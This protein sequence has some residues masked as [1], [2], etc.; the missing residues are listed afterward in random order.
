M[1]DGIPVY[2]AL[3]SDEDCGMVRIS[4]VDYPAVLTGWQKFKAATPSRQMYAIADE[5]KRI[6]FGVIMRADFPILRVDRDGEWYAIYRADTIRA[7][8]E[9]YLAEGRQ[10]RVDTDHNGNEVRGVQM[11][12][13]FIKDTARGINP[14]GFEEEVADGSLFA[15]FHIL[16]D[17][18][19][20]AIKDG[21]FRGFSLEGFFDF[22][23]D[24]DQQDIDSI[25]REL[26]EYCEHFKI[27]D[28]SKIEKTLNRLR[29]LLEAQNAQPQKFGR[30]TTDKGIVEW[31]GE[32]DLKE[33]DSVYILDEDGNRNAAADGEYMT[34]DG[35]T[36]VVVDG[37]VSE[38]RDP[39]AEVAPQ[40]ET[41]AEPEQAAEEDPAPAEEP[42]TPEAEPDY[43]A[44]YEEALERIAELEAALADALAGKEG[45]ET[46][47]AAARKEVTAL[48][49]QPIAAPAHEEVKASRQQQKT[50]VKS[51][52]RVAELM[53]K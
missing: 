8:A 53:S 35:K 13:W 37:K 49:A 22:Q 48:K 1:I 34:E 52:D 7:M 20:A 18:V 14:A 9:K 40:E 28:M 16:N 15:E 31:D 30:V 42:E 11:V 33:G 51:L 4:L 26:D 39:E 5:E 21:T 50:G 23:P 46:E 3:L 19:W 36:I 2:E 6:V 24:T 12:Q 47:L 43:K 29:E 10:N 41:P 44:L 27:E 25:V 45:A 17:D 32:E 38:I